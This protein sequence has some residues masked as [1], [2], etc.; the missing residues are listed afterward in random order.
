MQAWRPALALA[1]AQSD[2][3]QR[4]T[5]ASQVTRSLHGN[6]ERPFLATQKTSGSSDPC[7]ACGRPVRGG[8]C[9]AVGLLRCLPAPSAQPGCM[10]AHPVG[11]QAVPPAPARMP[12]HGLAIKQA[13]HGSCLWSFREGGT[14]PAR[15][16]LL[17][18][19]RVGTLVS[20]RSKSFDFSGVCSSFNH[21][22]S[23]IC[24]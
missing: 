2:S 11:K 3:G 19:P 5:V 1:G 24:L 14:S 10:F 8:P 7:R 23:V 9:F 22:C 21:L 12:V 20:L 13:C 17:H 6:P 4:R 15:C 16:P 18:H